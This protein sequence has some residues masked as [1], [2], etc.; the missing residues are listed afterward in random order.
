MMF[1]VWLT[2]LSGEPF[3]LP[4]PKPRDEANRT[5]RFFNEIPGVTAEVRP[6]SQ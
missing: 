4:G 1:T 3:A 6:V 5:A 2:A